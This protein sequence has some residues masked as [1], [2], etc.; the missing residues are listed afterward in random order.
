MASIFIKK[1]AHKKKNY[2]LINIMKKLYLYLYKLYLYN[3]K[4]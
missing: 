4:I 2:K 1:N 3:E